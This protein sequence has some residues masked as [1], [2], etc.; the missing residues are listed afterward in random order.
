MRIRIITFGCSAN[1]ADSELMAGLLVKAGH[2]LVKDEP[3]A[4]VINT[5]TVKNHTEAKI[6]RLLRSLKSQRVIVTGCMANANPELRDEFP[7]YTILGVNDTNRILEALEGKSIITDKPV[8]KLCLPKVRQDKLIDII[9]LSTGCLGHCNYCKTRQAKGRLHS[10]DK[11]LIIKHARL[12]LSE[13]AKE[14][15]L[16]SQDCGCYGFD[17]NTN[18]VEL[19]NE[20]VKLPGEFRIRIGMMNPQHA[21][22]LK[23]LPELFKHEKVYK[24]AHVPVQSGSDRVLLDMGRDYTASDFKELIDSLRLIVPDINVSTDVICG[25]PTET[26]SDWV[27]TLDLIKWLRP[28]WLNIS[29]FTPRPGTPASLLK[30]LKPGLAK[31]R[32]RELTSLFNEVMYRPQ[33]TSAWHTGRTDY[34]KLDK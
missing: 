22:K 12:A 14:L 20:L 27:L 4:Y 32:S 25:Y 15:W 5:C 18:L 23:G 2:E 24:F 17:I 28:G 1:T 6:K 33:K 9:Q 29:M 13:G 19:V 34:Y 7:D 21:L 26:E 30:Q 10:H 16:T 31:E 8:N 3:D 11:E